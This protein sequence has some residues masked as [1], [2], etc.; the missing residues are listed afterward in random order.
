M[1]I[2][3]FPNFQNKSLLEDA[4]YIVGYKADG[5]AEYRTTLSDVAEYLKYY[6]V[7]A[8]PP[9]G[10]VIL[11]DYSITPVPIESY[12]GLYSSVQFNYFRKNLYVNPA[13]NLTHIYFENNGC[14]GN[15]DFS[16]CEN[17]ELV[18]CNSNAIKNLNVTGCVKLTSINCQENLLSSLNISSALPVIKEIRCN[19]NSISHL[20]I[21]DAVNIKTLHCHNNSL[22]SL[23]ISNCT[24]IESF[25]C[26][27]N[28][29]VEL[30]VYDRSNLVNLKT[31][32][33]NLTSL[34]V[35]QCGNLGIL[36]CQ[37]N[38]LSSLDLTGTT[39]ISQLNVN[40]NYIESLNIDPLYD[41]V[42]LYCE[43]NKLNTNFS[44]MN[45]GQDQPNLRVIKAYNNQFD[46]NAVN[47]I[48]IS[49]NTYRP[50]PVSQGINNDHEISIGSNGPFET[51]AAPT[52][53]GLVAK[54]ELIAKGW[55]VYTS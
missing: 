34:D 30:N 46:E 45:I 36:W 47:S 14:G 19:D 37:N 32:H 26:R 35:R 10:S 33:N 43:N 16:S 5:T 13:T 21:S 2:I 22:S 49:M 15:L 53:L 31:N 6:F 40:N 54:N 29:L 38:A 23:N 28:A 48:L 1:A 25:E 27:G 51:N 50:D 3:K 42:D 55:R 52:G 11:S 24:L 17:L 18:G 9:T 7:E 39:G 8:T 12:A 41:L 44:F 4:D 20:D